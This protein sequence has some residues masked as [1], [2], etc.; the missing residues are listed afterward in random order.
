MFCC[1]YDFAYMAGTAMHRPTQLEAEAADFRE[2]LF[3]MY[4][5]PVVRL[6]CNPISSKIVFHTRNVSSTQGSDIDKGTSCHATV[7]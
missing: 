7:L 2:I 1:L 4:P 6:A 5:C 3:P